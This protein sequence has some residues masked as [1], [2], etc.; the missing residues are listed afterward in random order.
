MGSEGQVS[1]LCSNP[2]PQKSQSDSFVSLMASGEVQID[3]D[4]DKSKYGHSSGGFGDKSAY[5]SKVCLWI[6]VG[7]TFVPIFFEKVI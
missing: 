5:S 6:L 1:T 3:G 7:L 4:K 2:G